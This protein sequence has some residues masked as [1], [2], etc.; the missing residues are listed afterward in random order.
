MAIFEATIAISCLRQAA[1]DFLI[2]PT[3]AL[4]TSPPDL[5][6]QLLDAPDVLQL[7][8]QVEFEVAGFGPVQRMLHEITAFDGPSH[9][10]ETQLKGPLKSFVH[11]H[12]V[13]QDGDGVIV[14]DRI[15]FEPP[16]GLAGF[17]VT[18]ALIQKTLAG[19]FEHRHLTLK[20]ILEEAAD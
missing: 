3:N 14:I 12:L 6:V 2:R 9:F 10:T 4:L 8:S 18:E 16:G 1:F 11:E 5:T 19:G 20:R 7:G 17:I 13:E 15:A